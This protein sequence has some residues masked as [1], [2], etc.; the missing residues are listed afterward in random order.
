[1]GFPPGGVLCRGEGFD[2]PGT[3][4]LVFVGLTR[5]GFRV[6]GFRA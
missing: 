5:L 2:R 4:A 1:M 6:S 3:S